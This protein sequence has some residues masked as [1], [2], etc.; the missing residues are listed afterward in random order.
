MICFFL[1]QFYY[2]V[3]FKELIEFLSYSIHGMKLSVL[4][5]WC[6]L[7]VYSICGKYLSFMPNI[8]N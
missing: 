7:N 1:S 2:V 4:F 6:T 5:F 3:Y 8:G